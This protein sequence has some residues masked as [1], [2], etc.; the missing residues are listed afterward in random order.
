MCGE[1][2]ARDPTRH[3]PNVALAFLDAFLLTP[4]TDWEMMANALREH[5][6]AIPS[7]P[8]DC[9][10]GSLTRFRS[11][12]PVQESPVVPQTSPPRRPQR[13]R[14]SRSV[15]RPASRSP[16]R[17]RTRVERLRSRPRSL[18]RSRPRSPR[19]VA[20]QNMERRPF[21]PGQLRGPPKV[22]AMHDTQATR[23]LV[24]LSPRPSPPRDV[25]ARAKS[26]PRRS[27][28]PRRD[29][30]NPASPVTERQR[31]QS[32]LDAAAPKG[33]PVEM[34]PPDQPRVF[35]Q[36]P[37]LPPL[38]PVQQKGHA[39]QVPPPPQQHAQVPMMHPQQ[40]PAM[41]QPLPVQVPAQAP[42]HQQC[43]ARPPA[44]FGNVIDLEA[45]HAMCR[46][47][48]LVALRMQDQELQVLATQFMQM[49]NAMREQ[50]HQ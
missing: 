34:P 38:G 14:R 40:G 31:R 47:L 10:S 35:P 26:R 27:N 4:G 48:M 12:S 50:P 44:A 36:L 5:L 2:S 32:Q 43:M 6:T 37:V 8:E 29:A 46:N 24:D 18:S 42:M 15:R 28:S 20:R 11:L 45:F 25:R 33:R 7:R 9:R 17:S 1:S 23:T 19:D 13:R 3:H 39:Q 22:H 16:V 30:T 41:V 49:S 21:V